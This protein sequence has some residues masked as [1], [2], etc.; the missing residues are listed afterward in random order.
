MTDSIRVDWPKCPSCSGG[1]IVLF[2]SIA[3]CA[4]CCGTGISQSDERLQQPLADFEM[5]VRTRKFLRRHNLMT[6]GQLL[7]FAFKRRPEDVGG[8]KIIVAD[9]EQLLLSHHLPMGFWHA[10]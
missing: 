2:T 5:L 6:L 10:E 4:E 7:C 9:V 3:Q 8:D 1:R